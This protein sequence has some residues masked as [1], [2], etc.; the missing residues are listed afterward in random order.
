MNGRMW[1]KHSPKD[2][3]QTIRLEKQPPPI[4]RHQ[5]QS[6]LHPKTWLTSDELDAACF[7]LAEK[8]PAQDGLQSCLFF[9]C[10]HQGGVVGTP[11]KPFAQVLNV[12][13]NHWI[14]ASNIFCEKNELCFY[15]SLN[16]TV[17]KKTE[18]KLGR[19][20]AST[21]ICHQKACSA[22]AFRE[23]LWTV[24]LSFCFRSV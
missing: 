16:V 24:Y 11:D 22:G 14:T 1:M 4:E 20:S 7:L 5:L 17:T 19:S 21:F 3:I 9:Q 23:Q 2:L 13:D 15:D 6:I 10:L 8:F 18:H 12:N